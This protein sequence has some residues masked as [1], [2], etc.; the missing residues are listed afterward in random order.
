VSGAGLESKALYAI[1][2]VKSSMRC[3]LC[4]KNGMPGDLGPWRGR[5]GCK[6]VPQQPQCHPVQKENRGFHDITLGGARG[7]EM[8][9]ILANL[10]IPFAEESDGRHG[11][12]GQAHLG[13]SKR[14]AL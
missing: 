6:I 7:E 2:A 5:K 12:L 11:A 14:A 8:K 3:S 1:T 10:Q 13:I 9:R 4:S